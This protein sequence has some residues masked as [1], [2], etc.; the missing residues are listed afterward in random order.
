MFKEGKPLCVCL[1]FTLTFRKNI[2]PRNFGKPL[3]Q[4]WIVLVHSSDQ[5]YFF[6]VYY[7]LILLCNFSIYTWPLVEYTG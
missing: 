5:K 2:N 4:R 1:P 3:H 6:V 7:S